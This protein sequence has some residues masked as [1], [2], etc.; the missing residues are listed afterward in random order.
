MIRF[1][2]AA[3]LSL[4]LALPAQTEA[5]SVTPPA[6]KLWR[7]DCGSF[8]APTDAFSDLVSHPSERGSYVDSCY[9]VRHGEDLLLWDAGLPLAL[10]GK[11]EDASTP[12]QMQLTVTIVAQLAQIGLV[13]TDVT[14][15][16]IS[17]MHSD[18]T[19]QAAAFPGARLV[20]DRGDFEALRRTP[21]PF[22][23][24]P[25]T[26][27][28]WLDGG[29]ATE[30]ISGDHDVFGDGTVVMV[31]LPGHTPGNHGLLVRLAHTGPVLISGDALHAPEQLT[32]HALPPSNASR[33][34]SLAS[35]DRITG[36]VRDAD[37]TLI[38]GHDV[39][40]VAGLPAFPQAAE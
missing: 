15:L 22:F 30:L 8:T 20:M 2:S 16:G 17:H 13:P 3:V 11:P 39:G 18:H 36:I 33:S 31:A 34:D 12:I 4:G 24:D 25:S 1:L 23:T 14:V 35:I 40:S 26:L 19:G 32:S 10:L 21:P 27:R 5:E 7:L 9:L 37:A 6:I 29:S 28:P 38:V